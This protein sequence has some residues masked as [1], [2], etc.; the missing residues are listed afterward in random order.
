MMLNL[1]FVFSLPLKESRDNTVVDLKNSIN[2][3]EICLNF[4]YCRKPSDDSI[5]SQEIKS[6]K[7]LSV[8]I[9][10]DEK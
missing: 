4:I 6:K 9:H 5:D 10:I 3:C 1:F 8:K 7:W 2:L